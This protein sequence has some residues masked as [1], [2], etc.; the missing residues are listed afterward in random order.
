MGIKDVENNV[1]KGENAAYQQCFPVTLC[2]L[3]L[4]QI[5]DFT[6]AQIEDTCRQQNKCD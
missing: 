5:L 6:L 2:F 1:G 3:M 4:Y